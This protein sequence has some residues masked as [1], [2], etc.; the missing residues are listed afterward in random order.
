VLPR[1]STS[2]GDSSRTRSG[3]RSSGTIGLLALA[4]L[5]AAHLALADQGMAR[6]MDIN[7]PP[8]S[9]QVDC[10]ETECWECHENC[11]QEFGHWVMWEPLGCC[12]TQSSGPQCLYELTHGVTLNC[13]GEPVGPCEGPD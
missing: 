7:C 10:G 5:I 1:A 8:G 3:P 6:A 4:V 11:V 12:S 2:G 9:T 13:Q